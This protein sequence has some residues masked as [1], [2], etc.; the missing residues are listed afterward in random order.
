VVKVLICTGCGGDGA[1]KCPVCGGKGSIRRR[2]PLGERSLGSSVEC[3][4]CKG[5]K[6]ILCKMC[7]GVGKLL[8]DTRQTDQ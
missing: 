7:G 8:P 6:K 2:A 3:P 1:I 4:G 5:A